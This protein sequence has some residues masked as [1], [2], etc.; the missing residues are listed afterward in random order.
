MLLLHL[1]REP[2]STKRKIKPSLATKNRVLNPYLNYLTY[3]VTHHIHLLVS[4]DWLLIHGLTLWGHKGT[5]V[6]CEHMHGNI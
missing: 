4:A 3:H 5:K 1:K 2:L 6:K